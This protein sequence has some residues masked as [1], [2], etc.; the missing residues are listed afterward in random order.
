MAKKNI[1][2]T[3]KYYQQDETCSKKKIIEICKKI[4]KIVY[5]RTNQSECELYVQFNDE[6][7]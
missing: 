2:K 6:L 3:C 7:Q 4:E 1:C 5:V